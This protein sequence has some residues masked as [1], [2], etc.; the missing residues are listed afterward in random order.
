MFAPQGRKDLDDLTADVLKKLI[1]M[2]KDRSL[3]SYHMYAVKA[4]WV[5]AEKK[6]DDCK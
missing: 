5:I 4:I 2:L 3:I 6:W 1:A